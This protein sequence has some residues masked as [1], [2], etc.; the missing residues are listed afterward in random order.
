MIKNLLWTTFLKPKKLLADFVRIVFWLG[1]HVS[2]YNSPNSRSSS[3]GEASRK[4]SKPFLL[5]SVEEKD[6]D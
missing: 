4:Q 5:V 1:P 3:P 6:Y 2:R